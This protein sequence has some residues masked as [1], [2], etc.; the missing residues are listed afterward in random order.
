MLVPIYQE[1]VS[2]AVFMYLLH[3]AVHVPHIHEEMRAQNNM[4][5][6]CL[7]RVQATKACSHLR[8]Y[9]AASGVGSRV[10]THKLCPRAVGLRVYWEGVC[11]TYTESAIYKICMHIYVCVPVRYLV[12]SV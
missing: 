1:F 2:Y 7:V 12:N 3:R 5:A 6:L 4:I 9:A 10:C 8:L 11:D